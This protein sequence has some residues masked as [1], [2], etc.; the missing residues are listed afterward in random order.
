MALASRTLLLMLGLAASGCAPKDE[1]PPPPPPRPPGPLQVARDADI[2]KPNDL[3]QFRTA[4]E[5]AYRLKPDARVLLALADVESLLSGKPRPSVDARFSE[6]QWRLL[7]DGAEVGA[8]PEF[9]D[10]PQALAM[11]EARVQKLGLGAL[12]LQRGGATAEVPPLPL[13]RNALA[14]LHGL[15]RQWAAGKHT[16]SAVRGAAR[17]LVSLAF[18]GVD[19]TGTADEVPARALAMLAVARVATGEPLTEEQALLAASLGH[20]RAARE[21][22]GSL[23]EDSLV[24]LYLVQDDARLEKLARAEK[25][26]GLASYLRAR[27]VPAVPVT[28]RSRRLKQ[29]RGSPSVPGLHELA[30]RLH[31]WNFDSDDYW[32]TVTAVFVL[33]EVA[34]VA[35]PGEDARV[36]PRRASKRQRPGEEL[37]RQFKETAQ[38]FNIEQRGILP[39]FEEQLG[40]VGSQSGF[41]LDAGTERAWF[42]GLFYSALYRQE[43]H[44]LDKLSSPRAAAD[45]SK[46]LGSPSTPAGQEF[47]DWMGRLIAARAGERVEAPLMESLL[48]LKSFGAAPLVR[49]FEELEEAAD[50]GDPALSSM[51]R[52]LAARLDT[53]PGHRATLARIARSALL[54]VGLSE[55]LYRAEFEATGSPWVESWLAWLDR[56]AARLT[57]VVDSPSVPGRTRLRALGYLLKLQ[58]QDEPGAV[59]E[60][61]QPLVD[62]AGAEWAFV[63]LCVELLDERGL[64]REAR[65]VAERWLVLNPAANFLE[66]LLV[67]TA[68]ARAYQSEGNA[69]AGWMQVAPLISSYQ[70]GVMQRGAL[71]L[72]ELGKQDEAL[73]LAKRAAERYPGA[74]SLALVAEV[75]WRSGKHDEAAQA[76]KA[77]ARSL[78][79]LDWRFRIGDRFAAVFASRPAAE[80]LRAFT[81]LK[82]EGLGTQLGQLASAVGKAGNEELAF[83]LASRLEAPGLQQLELLMDAYAHLKRWKSEADAVAWLRTRVP[84]QALAPLSMFAFRSGADPVLWDVI[85]SYEGASEQEDYVWLMRA[86]ASLRSHDA[87]PAR[88]AALRKRFEVD[89]PGFYHQLGRYLLGLIPE[90]SVIAAATTPKSRQEM[91]FFL[92]LKAQAEDRFADA[93][94]WY[95]ATVETSNPRQGEYRWAFE[96]LN[97]FRQAELSLARMKERPR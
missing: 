10:F 58:K 51:T 86:A 90:P 25:V 45:F 92:G 48:G 27:R 50:W 47:Q 94:T 39:P 19:L 64:H 56:D 3:E 70:F 54:D 6:G 60:K 4:Y 29:P 26:P 95:R 71:L 1:T 84:Q 41:F 93:S 77:P 15:N 28:E 62:A 43:M 65:G 7:V 82:K 97:R 89:R 32:G 76:L 17:S 67:R 63:S 34:L 55:K 44:L 23:P 42:Q 46:K 2:A 91:T 40:R 16:A 35:N 18:Q 13:G 36:L 74:K 38:R 5:Q 88:Q 33:R 72:Q 12:E 59:M 20:E 73:A 83:E 49:V 69:E 75:L 9:P 21:L 31:A 79:S 66:K 24:R 61:L 78:R 96:E 11:L 85:P 30:A 57:A 68:I 80:G 52:R 8:L 22:A 81:A 37:A 87:D 14:S 53:R